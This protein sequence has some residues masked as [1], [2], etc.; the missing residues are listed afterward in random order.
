MHGAVLTL[1]VLVPATL[2]HADETPVGG[3][4][5]WTEGLG[6]VQDGHVTVQVGSSM[7]RTG[8]TTTYTMGEVALDVRLHEDATLKVQAG[9]YVDQVGADRMHARGFEDPGI[10][11]KLGVAEGVAVVVGTTVPHSADEMSSRVW[12]PS[13]RAV[14]GHALGPVSVAANLQYT[15]TFGGDAMPALVAASGW[16]GLQVSYRIAA[17]AEAYAERSVDAGAAT[18]G[19]AHGGF[20]VLVTNDLQLDVHAGQGLTPTAPERLAGVGLT[21]RW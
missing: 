7:E 11:V 4:S 15:T 9:S 1:A 6:G 3:R 2:A 12:S 8:N 14:V 5:G 13:L 21:R 19:V 18:Q 20:T 10:G 16:V 17:F